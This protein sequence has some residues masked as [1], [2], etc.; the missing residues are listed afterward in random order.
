MKNIKLFL[1]RPKL[2]IGKIKTKTYILKEL[3]KVF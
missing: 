2:D 1:L 3:S